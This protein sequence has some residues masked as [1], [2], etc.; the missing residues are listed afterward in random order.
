MRSL[1]GPYAETFQ[2]IRAIG[3]KRLFIL[4]SMSASFESLSESGLSVIGSMAE[5]VVRLD[6]RCSTKGH[7]V[8]A[9]TSKCSE[10]MSHFLFSTSHFKILIQKVQDDVLV[11]FRD[12]SDAYSGH[13]AQY[14][15][16][17]SAFHRTYQLANEAYVT[18]FKAYLDI[19]ERINSIADDFRDDDQ[20]S[21]D[22]LRADCTAREGDVVIQCAR[23]GQAKREY[24]LV[25]EKMILRFEE[26]E[27]EFFTKI[28]EFSDGFARVIDS[29]GAAF[30]DA[31]PEAARAVAQLRAAIAR[32]AEPRAVGTSNFVDIP[33]LSPSV[34]Q[35]LKPETILG[36][37]VALMRIAVRKIEPDVAEK[38]DFLLV[39][40]DR[41]KDLY[42][43]HD[44][45]GKFGVVAVADVIALPNGG[46]KNFR[47]VVRDVVVDGI[48]LRKG[49]CVLIVGPEGGPEIRCHIACHEVV[50]LPRTAVKK[51]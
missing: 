20:A 30:V 34:F 10:W 41:G 38:G 2:R 13:Y 16:D 17:M 9:R 33:E 15:V 1:T 42:V 46:R 47:K 11:P 49:E 51:I 26:T 40:E 14:E 3:Q 44:V 35:F 39:V 12:Y 29:F 48:A 23:L 28:A 22:E 4:A 19:C 7:D 32:P 5:I 24:A 25:A 31:A 50:T 43:R 21:F 37:I 36:G 45:S 27:R 6:E 18:T 8:D